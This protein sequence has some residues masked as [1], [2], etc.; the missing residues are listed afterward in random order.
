MRRAGRISV[1]TGIGLLELIVVLAIALVIPLLV[2]ERHQPTPPVTATTPSEVEKQLNVLTQQEA[3]LREHFEHLD[4]EIA[5]LEQSVV[6]MLAFSTLAVAVLFGSILFGE[7]RINRAAEDLESRAEEAKR[8]FPKLAE[9]EEML[10]NALDD[11]REAF[12]E[13]E[14]VEDRYRDLSIELRQHILTVERLFPLQFKDV[15]ASQL[16]GLANF[17]FSKYNTEHVESDLDRALYYADLACKRNNGGF[18]YKNDLGFIYMDLARRDVEYREKAERALL[19]SKRNHA[20]Q[21]RCYYNL[22]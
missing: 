18:Q 6:I 2:P 14:W 3:E 12:R 10:R 20:S 8:R 9:F 13:D 7:Y 5:H 16:R 17:F 1:L 22:G 19:D 21:Q 11:Y 15:T 4:K